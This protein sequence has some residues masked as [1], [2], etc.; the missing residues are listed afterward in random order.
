[1]LLFEMCPYGC[2][3]AI[4]S[5]AQI[6]TGMARARRIIASSASSVLLAGEGA[7]GQKHCHKCAVGALAEFYKCH[8]GHVR[9]VLVAADQ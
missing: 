2:S 1:M 8:Y 4:S 9:G 6:L 5:G 7:W 3:E